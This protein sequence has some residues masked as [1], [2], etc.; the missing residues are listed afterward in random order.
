MKTDEEYLDNYFDK[1]NELKKK[2]ELWRI[3]VTPQEFLAEIGKIRQYGIKERKGNYLT[4]YHIQRNEEV[5][6]S[7]L[8]MDRMTKEEFI[9]QCGRLNKAAK[10]EFAAEAF[11]IQLRV[12]KLQTPLLFRDV[13][14]IYR[15][16]IREQITPE[17]LSINVLEEFNKTRQYQIYIKRI[18]RTKNGTS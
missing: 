9:E 1:Y 2:N 6:I 4:D 8:L 12:K 7:V 17:M 5:M 16:L 3:R 18:N 11:K 13:I 14:N 15:W 10:I